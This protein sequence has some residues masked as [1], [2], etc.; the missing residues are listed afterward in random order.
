MKNLF[1]S[2][3]FRSKPSTDTNLTALDSDGK[4]KAPPS[5]T[6]LPNPSNNNNDD[7]HPFIAFF[8]AI[9]V[10]LTFFAA[11]SITQTINFFLQQQIDFYKPT[12]YFFQSMTYQRQVYEQN[13]LVYIVSLLLVVLGVTSSVY[14]VKQAWLPTN[15]RPAHFVYI[16]K[17]VCVVFSFGLIATL[18]DVTD[19]SEPVRYAC[20]GGLWDLD[21]DNYLA[22]GV[23]TYWLPRDVR[24]EC[25]RFLSI[26]LYMVLLVNFDFSVFL[27]MVLIVK[28]REGLVVG[29]QRPGM[30]ANI[31]GWAGNLDRTPTLED[32]I[33]REEDTKI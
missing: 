8:R 33:N 28:L 27:L 5:A 1:A 22:R 18:S 12:N 6:L 7:N 30:W 21:Y 10:F 3:Q 16:A 26:G 19:P 13:L 25:A 15:S 31:L 17:L 20:V 23:S 4:P 11:A 9:P 32:V 2:R 29:S 14:A 24:H